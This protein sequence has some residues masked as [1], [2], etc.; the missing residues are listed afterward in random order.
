MAQIRMYKE[1]MRIQ[2][3]YLS[4]FNFV[5]QQL[6]GLELVIKRFRSKFDLGSVVAA[7]QAYVPDINSQYAQLSQTCMHRLE[8]LQSRLDSISLQVQKA[9]NK[10]GIVKFEQ[11][12]KLRDRVNV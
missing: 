1:Q 9:R 3:T 10:Q 12:Q 5:Q 2:G 4:Q 7:V 11:A 8:Q 6:R